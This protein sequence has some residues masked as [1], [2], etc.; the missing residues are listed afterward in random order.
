MTMMMMTMRLSDICGEEL[1]STSSATVLS[2]TTRGGIRRRWAISA[3]SDEHV[4]INV[5]SVNLP[6][7]M[8]VDCNTDYLELRDQPLV[9]Q[10]YNNNNIITTT[11]NNSI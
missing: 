9:C 3:P 8:S 6:Y 1:N 4:E 10:R 7:N 11:N 2:Y 5:T